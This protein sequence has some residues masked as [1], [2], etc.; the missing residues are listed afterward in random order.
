MHARQTIAYGYTKPVPPSEL[1]TEPGSW[2]AW[3][4]QHYRS[5]S[6]SGYAKPATIKKWAAKN[7][8]AYD[9]R[10]K[11]GSGHFGFTPIDLGE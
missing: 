6:W 7:G 5:R 2:S 1:F 3:F 10:A 11:R 4:N 9:L 8:V